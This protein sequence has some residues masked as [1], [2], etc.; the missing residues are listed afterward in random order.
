MLSISLCSLLCCPSSSSPCFCCCFI[1]TAPIFLASAWIRTY[2]CGR[3]C[4]ELP[5]RNSADA[6]PRV[7][8]RTA[9]TRKQPS[10]EDD[11]RNDRSIRPILA[12]AA[13]RG[14]QKREGAANAP[15]SRPAALIHALSANAEQRSVNAPTVALEKIARIDHRKRLSM[16]RLRAIYPSVTRSPPTLPLAETRAGTPDHLGPRLN[17]HPQPRPNPLLNLL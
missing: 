3:T 12:T 4:A 5:Q 16:P 8:P 11:R 10:G 15:D 17:Q 2:L 13:A 1:C 14:P 7:T 6:T 9:L